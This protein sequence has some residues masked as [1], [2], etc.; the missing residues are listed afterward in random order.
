MSVRTSGF[1]SLSVEVGVIVRVGESVTDGFG[2]DNILVGVL[3]EGT[4]DGSTVAS[5]SVGVNVGREVRV[6][7]NLISSGLQA[8]IQPPA[9]ANPTNFRKFLLGS[10]T[11]DIT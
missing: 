7:C 3:V 1:G 6:G 11:G 2:V 9:N 5:I 4:S 8:A 10:F